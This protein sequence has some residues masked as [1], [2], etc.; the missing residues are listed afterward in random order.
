MKIKDKLNSIFQSSFITINFPFIQKYGSKYSFVF[1]D[2]KSFFNF[3]ILRNRKQQN[4]SSFRLSIFPTTFC[5]ANCVF[6][7]NKYFKDRRETMSFDIFKKSVDEYI[8]LGGKSVGLT[9]SPGEDLLDA[10]FFKKVEYLNKKGVETSLYTNGIL[11]DKY[12]NEIVRTRISHLYIDIGDIIPR[13]DSEVF[14]ISQDISKKRISG[15]LKLLE[16]LDKKKIKIDLEI[17]FRPQRK[18]KQ[19]FNDMKKSD[20]WKYYKKGLFR[21]SFLQSYDNWCGLVKEK[22]LL[23]VQTIKL[24]PKIKRYPC[25]AFLNLSVLPNGD[26]RVCGCRYLNTLDDDLVIGNIKKSS[27]KDMLN[28][29]KY[30]KLFSDFFSGK[31]PD[32]CRKCSF[33]RPCIS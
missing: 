11:I 24:A 33:Y 6:C 32:V 20:F 28:S 12:I 30:K 3:Y 14:G 19:I 22:D 21:I 2:I 27:L 16:E 26:V 18:P 31:M 29:E 4:V 7:G 9:P 10:G 13:Y 5:N 17:S 8:S 1:D 15:I 23:G 25:L